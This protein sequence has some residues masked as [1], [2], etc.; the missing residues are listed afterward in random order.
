[1]TPDHRTD[2]MEGAVLAEPMTI[3]GRK[4]RKFTLPTFVL[5][6]RTKNRL[7]AGG[8]TTVKHPDGR[9]IIDFNDADNVQALLQFIY[10]HSAPMR[11]VIVASK[12]AEEFDTAVLMHTA[13]IS[14]RDLAAA[15]VEITSS[16]ESAA[17]ALVEDNETPDQEGDSDPN[18]PG[19][20]G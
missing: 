16:I 17:A 14:M 18:A 4:L 11:D 6:K 1:M 3:A 2:L 7:V 15:S 20:R 19:P 10:I 13:D 9:D 12:D 5:L 8:M